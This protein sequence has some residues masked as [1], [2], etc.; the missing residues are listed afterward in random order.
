MSSGLPVVLSLLACGVWIG[1]L[2]YLSQKKWEG[3]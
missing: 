2:A 3:E 1:F